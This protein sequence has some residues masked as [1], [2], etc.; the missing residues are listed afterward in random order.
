MKSFLFRRPLSLLWVGLLVFSS[1]ARK[2]ATSD[3]TNVSGGNVKPAAMPTL[4]KRETI[5]ARFFLDPSDKGTDAVLSNGVDPLT[6]AFGDRMKWEVYGVA[7]GPSEPAQTASRLISAGID[8]AQKQDKAIAFLKEARKSASSFSRGTA[9]AIA[10]RLALK[11]DEFAR[12]MDSTN[13]E[14][15]VT[16]NSDKAASFSVRFVP[17]LLIED[18]LLIGDEVKPEVY[19]R[20]AEGYLNGPSN[21]TVTLLVFFDPKCKVCNEQVSHF[22]VSAYENVLPIRVSVD[23]PENK[24]LAL[25]LGLDRVPS[26]LFRGPVKT[27]KD[28]QKI[29]KLLRPLSSEKDLYEIEVSFSAGVRKFIAPVPKIR[30]DHVMGDPKAPITVYDFSD[31]Q[32]PAC[33]NLALNILPQVKRALIDQGRARWAYVH[34]PLTQAHEYAFTA[35]VASE[36]VARQGKFWQYHDLIFQNQKALNRELL[37]TLAARLPGVSSEKFTACMNEKSVRD[38]VAGDAAIAEKLKFPGTPTLIVGPYVTG[39]LPA[40]ELVFLVETATQ[41]LATSA[42]SK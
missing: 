30:E 26:Y 8:C 24:Q 36:C 17:A 39:S 37:Y 13:P 21:D 12:C 35:A 42:A 25:S 2:T 34:F 38:I 33:Q 20:V 22:I 1:C 31:F 40:E 16:D 41:E 23:R 6:Q 19:K 15:V 29:D 11:E 5:T 10:K 7:W 32:C 9:L 27:L 14:K 4:S 3:A 28:Y 18:A